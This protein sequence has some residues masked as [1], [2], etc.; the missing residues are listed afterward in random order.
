LQ[1]ARAADLVLVP[2]RPAILDFEAIA[3]SLD[4]V[5]T[6]GTPAIVV[7]NAVAP[8]GS[9]MNEAAEAIAGLGVEVCPVRLVNRVAFSRSLITGQTASEFQ[10]EGKAGQEAFTLQKFT[11]ERVHRPAKA[12]GTPDDQQIRQR[13]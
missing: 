5:C 9:E 11:C 7:L 4:L 3:A 6:T 1:A 10:P 12:K 13:A 2:C 8:A